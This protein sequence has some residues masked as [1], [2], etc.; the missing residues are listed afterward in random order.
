MS[1]PFNLGFSGLSSGLQTK[2]AA[3]VL[4]FGDDFS[5]YADQ[6]A[7]DLAWPTSNT[8]QARVNISN[9]NINIIFTTA[10]LDEVPTIY[11]DLTSTSNE[12]WVLRYK[13]NLT[14]I[15][16]PG[17]YNFACF[18]A[19][20]DNTSHAGISQ[21]SIGLLLL[22][23]NGG[24]KQYKCYDR[25]NALL[26]EADPPTGD[27]TFSYTPVTGTIYVQITRSSTTAYTVKLYSDATYTTLIETA[28]GTT[29]STV[30]NLRYIK[31]GMRDNSGHATGALTATI[32]DIE[33][34]NGVNSV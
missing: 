30:T 21:D 1:L 19:L 13:L 6:T 4:T 24:T 17:N 7:A 18:M 20:S 29:V 34:Y 10:N 12:K 33:F 2:N 23:S 22:I 3:V 15:T 5:S 9:D 28:S 8:G 16:A 14:T 25:D 31:F 32:D 27:V 11:Y 26:F